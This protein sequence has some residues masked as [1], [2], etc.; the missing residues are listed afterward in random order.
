MIQQEEIKNSIL[1]E[2][3]LSSLADNDKD[4]ILSRLGEGL[5]KRIIAVTLEKLPEEA[6]GEFEALNQAGDNDKINQFLKN[7]IPGVE[8]IIQQ[9]IKEGIEEFKNIAT[10]LR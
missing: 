3:G 6:R 2:L 10:K 9:E 5:L 7:N 4:E 8:Q 1:K